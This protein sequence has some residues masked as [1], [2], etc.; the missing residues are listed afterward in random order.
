LERKGVL[1][2]MR[3]KLGAILGRIEAEIKGEEIP[4][5]RRFVFYLLMELFHFLINSD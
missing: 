3:K 1:E 5:S 2:N 4:S